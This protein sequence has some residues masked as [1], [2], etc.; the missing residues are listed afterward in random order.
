MPIYS[1]SR[2]NFTIKQV[3][4]VTIQSRPLTTTII[5][6]SAMRGV[7]GK[8]QYSLASMSRLFYNARPP[9][10]SCFFISAITRHS[11]CPGHS[12]A[13]LQP[14]IKMSFSPF[15]IARFLTPLPTPMIAAEIITQH[16]SSGAASGPGRHS[17]QHVS[18]PQGALLLHLLPVMQA[19]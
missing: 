11:Q 3:T 7:I 16:T 18:G 19:G 1:I 15:T 9:T 14:N 17:E 6:S 12:H 8:S 2:V 5:I 4:E 10:L 13:G